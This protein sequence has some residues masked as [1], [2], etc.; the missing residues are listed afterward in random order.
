MINYFNKIDKG[1]K[2]GEILSIVFLCAVIP[3]LYTNYT[4]DPVLHPRFVAWTIFLIG[5]ISIYFNCPA[6]TNWTSLRVSIVS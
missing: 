6:P 4:I 3:F 1:Q 2:M 5:S